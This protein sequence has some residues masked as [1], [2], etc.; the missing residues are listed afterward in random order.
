M[1]NTK[2]T[3]LC[4]MLALVLCMSFLITIVMRERDI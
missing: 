1:K 3:I 2:K 4:L